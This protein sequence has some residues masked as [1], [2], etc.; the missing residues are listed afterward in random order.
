MPTGVEEAPLRAGSDPG[1]GMAFNPKQLGACK[2]LM[3]ELSP[4]QALLPCCED[5]APD[6]GPA[7]THDFI[8][9]LSAFM[10]LTCKACMQS[11]NWN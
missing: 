6:L 1:E 4:L 11:I 9:V 10:E 5:P 7:G 3:L 8:F 2:C